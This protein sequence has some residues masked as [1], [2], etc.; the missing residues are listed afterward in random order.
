MSRLYIYFW[1][2]SNL[3]ILF[4]RTLLVNSL[5]SYLVKYKNEIFADVD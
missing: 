4:R 1:R 5:K 2:F 3:F